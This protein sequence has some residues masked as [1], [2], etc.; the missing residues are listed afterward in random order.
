MLK[1]MTS[2]NV[3]LQTYKRTH[4]LTSDQIVFCKFYL[5]RSRQTDNNKVQPCPKSVLIVKVG[6]HAGT[7]ASVQLTVS[8]VLRL[9]HKER[10]AS[11]R[12]QGVAR[13]AATAGVEPVAFVKLR[14]AVNEKYRR[15]HIV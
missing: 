13:V 11:A 8:N 6:A 5:I 12:L 14:P 2:L 15:R 3:D 10:L 7:T 9:R 4:L 1:G